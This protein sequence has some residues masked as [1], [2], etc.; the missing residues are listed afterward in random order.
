MV[1]ALGISRGDEIIMPSFTIISCVAQI[2]RS[3][4][5]P[6]LVDSDQETWNMDINQVEDN[7]KTKAIMAVHIYGLPV[8][9]DP[10]LDL[11]E[12]YGLKVI[13]DAAE[14]I[15]QTYKVNPGRLWRY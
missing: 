3:G 13:E 5:K 15:G 9:L 11:A 7:A 6:I 2:I 14:M 10:I 8:D 4:A 1:E 12:K